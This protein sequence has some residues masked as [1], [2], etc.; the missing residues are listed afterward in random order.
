MLATLWPGSNPVARGGLRDRGLLESAVQSPFQSAFG[1]D[2]YP[3]IEE[4]GAA[5]FRSLNANHPFVD[6]NKRTS[7]VALLIFFQG[8]SRLWLLGDEAR[9]RLATRT[10][11]YRERGVSHEDCFVEILDAFRDSVI[12]FADVRKAAKN[13]APLAKRYR[14]LLDMRWRLRKGMKK[15][16]S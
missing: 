14:D 12:S 10:A 15:V 5:L 4:K 16:A 3:S 1:E 7:V 6:G 8:N 2:A 13:S 11:S 9:Y